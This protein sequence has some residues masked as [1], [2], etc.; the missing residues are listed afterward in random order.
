MQAASEECSL[1]QEVLMQ[2][3][4]HWRCTLRCQVPGAQV[5]D[6][7]PTLGGAVGRTEVCQD[8][9]D[10]I[11][12]LPASKELGGK[13]SSEGHLALEACQ[14]DDRTAAKLRLWVWFHM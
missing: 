13:G 8:L 14:R 11:S 12:E 3:H 4:W 10:W 9:G 7:D 1:G 5:G 2:S 6:A